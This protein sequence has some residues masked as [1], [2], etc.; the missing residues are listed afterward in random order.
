[1]QMEG[2]TM[3]QTLASALTGDYDLRYIVDIY[4]DNAML[5]RQTDCIASRKPK[6]AP[7]PQAVIIS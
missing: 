1:M 2:E 3:A 5:R 7:L 6:T 4:E